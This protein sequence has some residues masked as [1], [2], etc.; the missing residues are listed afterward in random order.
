MI[1]GQAF[2]AFIQA[3]PISVMMRGIVENTKEAC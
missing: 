3:S 1:L 2:E